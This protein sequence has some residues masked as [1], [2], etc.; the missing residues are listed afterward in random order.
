MLQPAGPDLVVE[1]E[2]GF[3]CREEG[4][5]FNGR[6]HVGGEETEVDFLEVKS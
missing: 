3:G 1:L 5:R 2:L 4:V 6:V